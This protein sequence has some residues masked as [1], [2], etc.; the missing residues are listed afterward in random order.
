MKRPRVDSDCEIKQ[1]ESCKLVK[2]EAELGQKLSDLIKKKKKFASK[3]A[4]VILSFDQSKS[5]SDESEIKQENKEVEDLVNEPR[6]FVQDIQR[7][8][9]YALIGNNFRF[10]PRYFHYSFSKALIFDFFFNTIWIS[11]GAKSYV[12][13]KSSR[14]LW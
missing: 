11:D 7:V 12:P 9:L 4:K 13:I 6:F 10:F 8:I 5:E 14:L 1:E 3:M 2:N